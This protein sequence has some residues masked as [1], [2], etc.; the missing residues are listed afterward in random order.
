MIEVAWTI[1]REARLLPV[2]TGYS[3]LT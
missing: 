2:R 3:T 1:R